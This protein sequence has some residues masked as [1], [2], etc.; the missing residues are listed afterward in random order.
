MG[1]TDQFKLVIK[2]L[3]SFHKEYP[4]HTMGRLFSGAFA[5]YGDTWGTS[6]KEFLFAL[7]KC[8]T[9]ME[10]NL[11]PEEE[12]ARIIEEGKNLEKLFSESD[13]EDD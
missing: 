7:E 1:Q 5:E 10:L 6:D 2:F 11:E 9:E 12:L 8:K 4:N 13:E 3:T